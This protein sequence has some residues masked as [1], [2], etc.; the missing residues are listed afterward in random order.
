MDW[1]PYLHMRTW[2]SYLLIYSII[3]NLI[4]S[5]LICTCFLLI[6]LVFILI[7]WIFHLMLLFLYMILIV[8][9]LGVTEWP[10]ICYWMVY[11]ILLV[12]CVSVAC[13]AH[14]LYRV[15]LIYEWN[16]VYLISFCLV[17][18]LIWFKVFNFLYFVI[19][20]KIDLNTINIFYSI[21]SHYLTFF[22]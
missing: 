6:A 16:M 18:C 15:V 22:K 8:I 11:L 14:F 9:V 20:I 1:S 17:L 4:R 7:V 21:S 3:A 2:T 5:I 19:I 10:F 13:V 12:G